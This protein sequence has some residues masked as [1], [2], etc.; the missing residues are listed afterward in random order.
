MEQE[1]HFLERHG[2]RLEKAF[3]AMKP[4][5]INNPETAFKRFSSPDVAITIL[6]P[7]FKE[8]DPLIYLNRIRKLRKPFIVYTRNPGDRF[9]VEAMRLGACDVLNSEEVDTELV[10]DVM[11]RSYMESERWSRLIEIRN[12]SLPSPYPELDFMIQNRVFEESGSNGENG[13]MGTTL[14]RYTDGK[15][16]Q[17]VFA[18]ISLKQWNMA[19]PH[20][21]NEAAKKL[22]HSGALIWSVRSEDLLCGFIEH[23]PRMIVDK[24]LEV[25]VD[26]ADSLLC[27]SPR[28]RITTSIKGSEMVYREDLS[29]VYATG[30]NVVSHTLKAQNLSSGFYIGQDVHST[31]SPFQRGLFNHLIEMDGQSMHGRS[32]FRF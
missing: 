28:T 7:F 15:L 17:A 5:W 1:S 21:L 30:L 26:L 8:V 32:A 3:S 23:D 11:V 12:Q 9:I 4:E 13:Q 19:E 25:E 29:T 24:L 22:E 27:T 6:D 16:Y 31:L 10:R 18:G 20:L 14:S 2:K